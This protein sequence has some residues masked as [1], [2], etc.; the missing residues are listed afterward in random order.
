MCVHV[1][2]IK[3]EVLQQHRVLLA[4]S[5]LPE[6]K[7]KTANFLLYIFLVKWVHS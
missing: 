1:P 2:D 5:L 6:F 7:K 4:A 3:V